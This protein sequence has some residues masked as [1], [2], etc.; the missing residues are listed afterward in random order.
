MHL[1]FLSGIPRSGSTLLSALLNQRTDTYVSPTS[2]LGETMGAAITAW[3]QNPATKASG[4]VEDDAIRMLHGIAT[5]QYAT[6]TESIVIDKGRGWPAPQIMQ[7]MEKVLGKENGGMK[8]IATVR[9]IADCLASLVKIAKPD[10]IADFCKNSE[11]AKHLFASYHT[12]KAGYEAQPENFCIVEYDN[13]V[14]DPQKELDRIADFLGIERQACDPE[15]IDAVAEDDKAWGIE[16]LHTVRPA[17]AKRDYSPC[18]I[19]GGKLY[20]FYQ[21]GAFWSAEEEAPRPPA[22]LDLSL[23]AALRGEVDTAW[24]LLEQLRIADPE[25]D[26]AAFNRGWHL[27]R[28]GKFREGNAHLFRGRAEGVFGNSHPGTGASIWDESPGKTVMLMLEG[29]LGDQIHGARFVRDIV[30][31]GSKAVV[32]CAVELA[33]LIKDIEGVSALCQPEALRGVYHDAWLPSMSAAH[34]LGYEKAEGAPYIPRTAEAVPGR[35]GIRWS[36]NPKFEHEQ[37]RLFPAHLLF[38]AVEGASDDIISLQ[39]DEGAELRPSWV[40]EVDLSDWKATRDAVSSCERVI[41]SCTSV[42]HLAGAMGVETWIV[43]PI[44]PYYLW[45]YPGEKTAHYD[46]VTLFRQEVYGEWAAPFDTI[47]IRLQKI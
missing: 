20:T 47:R 12:L 31:A 3:E 42:A 19:L 34:F 26:R 4:G 21:G 29:G 9:P 28:Q 46:S 15:H 35:I 23:A 22:I 41:T 16:G 17:V 37:H 38:D 24:E 1:H 32:A 11:L 30:A 5:A 33:P 6:R 43:V 14:A 7:T 36:G 27:L 40:K 8:I 18:E 10:N 13:L 45:A 25:D 2:S 44:L 39:R